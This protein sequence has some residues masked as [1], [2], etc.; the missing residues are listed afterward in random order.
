MNLSS[1]KILV[2]GCAGFIGSALVRRLVYEKANVI[3]IDNINDYY[4]VDLKLAR[5]EE[6]KNIEKESKWSFDLYKIS[7]E[8]FNALKLINSKYDIDIV[9]HLAAQAGVRHSLINPHSYIDA[10]LVAFGNI[11]EICKDQSISNFVFASSSSVYGGNKLL[12][13][14]E[15]HVVNCPLNLYAATKR[16]NE[17]MAFSYSHLY[18]IPTT[19]L[20]FFTVYGPWGR[21][22]MDLLFL[23]IQYLKDLK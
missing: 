3:G 11:L 2:T 5:L 10:N 12:P 16:S 8:D 13:F 15:N 21:P 19:G 22:D 18:K 9:V 23:Q 1:K 14:K 20:R 17:L 4:S 7:L 6:I